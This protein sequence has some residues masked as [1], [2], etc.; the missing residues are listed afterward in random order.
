MRQV[1]RR[2]ERLFLRRVVLWK[3]SIFRQD[4]LGT[5]IKKSD[6][7]ESVFETGNARCCDVCDRAVAGR[8]AAGGSAV[9]GHLAAEPEALLQPAARLIRRA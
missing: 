7:R 4:R 8:S 6:I 3:T 5:N 1:P 9:S 2:R